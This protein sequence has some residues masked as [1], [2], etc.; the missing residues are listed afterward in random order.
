MTPGPGS[1]QERAPTERG[2]RSKRPAPPVGMTTREFLR[3]AFRRSPPE[4]STPFREMRRRHPVLVG[5]Q[6]ACTLGIAA[7]GLVDLVHGVPHRIWGG[8]YLLL[9]TASVVL[10]VMLI[11]RDDPPSER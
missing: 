6:I 11:R 5:L 8:V 9:L 10:W 3:E 1:R 7:F 2:A 4:R